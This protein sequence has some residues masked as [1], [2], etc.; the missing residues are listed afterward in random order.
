MSSINSVE[1]SDSTYTLQVSGGLGST[2]DEDNDSNPGT[3]DIADVQRS[4]ASAS[5]SG[6]GRLTTNR[7]AP[8]SGFDRS[9]NNLGAGLGTF[10][11]PTMADRTNP[12]LFILTFKRNDLLN[13]T[14]C[15]LDGR[16]V[17]TIST[18]GVGQ[19]SRESPV[20]ALITDFVKV[21]LTE[22][23]S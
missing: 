13:N 17:Y 1:W 6:N 11:G 7:V 8:P 18:K 5:S 22:V 19:L 15:S 9:N 3:K 12:N 2:G 10:V 20:T 4:S 23:C 14:L 21:G 16:T